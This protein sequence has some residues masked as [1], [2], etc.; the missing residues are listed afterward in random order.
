MNECFLILAFEL[1]LTNSTVDK[2]D[3]GVAVGA[4][5]GGVWKAEQE[6]ETQPINNEHDFD[7][8]LSH[9]YNSLKMFRI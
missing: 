8:T 4:W 3:L 7:H 1:I 6:Q 9:K 2:K 5:K